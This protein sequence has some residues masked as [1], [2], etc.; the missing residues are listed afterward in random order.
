MTQLTFELAGRAAFGRADFFVSGSNAAALAWLDR[1]P[2]WPA[3][4]MVLHGPRGSG[5]THLLHLWCARASASLLP[6][7]ALD[8]TTLHH[9]LSRGGRP[10]AIDDADC[11]GEAALLHLFNACREG[12]GSLLLAVR[13]L[14]G[15]W[16]ARLPDLDSRLRAALSV[17]IGLP[18]DSLLGVVL[19]KH[20]ADRQV[21]VAPEV[22]AYLVGHIDRSLAAAAEI[23]DVLDQDALS[24]GSAI[25]VPLARRLLAERRDRSQPPDGEPAVT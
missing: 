8:E 16:R 17:G 6:G 14:A 12:G 23:A 4:A 10:V 20:F 22:I 1:W 21:R 2:D 13:T 11:A 7:A 15:A 9:L 25:T 18:D 5:K 19:T 24:G 3:P